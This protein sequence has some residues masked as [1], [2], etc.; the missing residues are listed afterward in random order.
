MEGTMN[1]Q[2]AAFMTESQAN[3]ELALMQAE[4]DA[5]SSGD[6]YIWLTESGLPSDASIR[7]KEI[8]DVTRRISGKAISLGKI[9]VIKL[10]EFV[11]AHPNLA[12]GV[13]LGAAISL[14]ISSIPLLGSLLAPVALPLGIIVGAIAG[15]RLD[16]GRR[17]GG[18]SII[19]ISQEVIELARYFFQDLIDMLFALKDEFQTEPA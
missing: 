11:K 14:L 12:V 19:E 13:A 16:Q 7:L 9:I 3:L 6:L 18:S 4:A 5:M 1:S 10:I 8:I 2:H 17:K 15:H